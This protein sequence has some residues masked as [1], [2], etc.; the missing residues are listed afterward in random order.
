MGELQILIKCLNSSLGLALLSA[1]SA[2]NS[3]GS[4]SLSENSW[5]HLTM[6]TAMTI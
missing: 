3:R 2:S 6:E 1:D 5:D 4:I